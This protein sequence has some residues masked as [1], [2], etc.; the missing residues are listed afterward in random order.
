MNPPLPT[1]K[2]QTSAITAALLK[3]QQQID[4]CSKIINTLESRLESVLESD[5]TEQNLPEPEPFSSNVPLVNVLEDMAGIAN[6]SRSQLLR[7]QDN[8]AL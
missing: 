2:P 8:L 4:N 7:I 5:F 1:D 6:R 3:L